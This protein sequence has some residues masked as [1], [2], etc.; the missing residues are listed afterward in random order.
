MRP[1]VVAPADVQATRSGVD[2]VERAVD[3]VDDELDPGEELA[4]RPVGEEVVAL[5]GEVGRVDLQQEAP[6]DDRS[7]LGA[8]RRR[9]RA[10]VV[11]EVGVVAVLHRRGDDARRR[12]GHER[13]RERRVGHA[14][15]LGVELACVAVAHLGRSPPERRA[16]SPSRGRRGA[17]ASSM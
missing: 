17:G 9:E 3:R 4:E 13:L 8:Q 1:L 14:R 10:D 5:H 12:R 2:A 15:A 16:G 11:V 6:L 7:V